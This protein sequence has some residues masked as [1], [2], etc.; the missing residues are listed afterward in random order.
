MSRNHRTNRNAPQWDRP[1]ALGNELTKQVPMT[2]GRCEI[3]VGRDTIRGTDVVGSHTDGA[4]PAREDS[5]VIHL[6]KEF[7]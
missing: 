3:G 1:R 5:G 7:Q 2:S 4:R 6:T